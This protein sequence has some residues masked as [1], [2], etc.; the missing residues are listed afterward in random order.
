[1]PGYSSFSSSLTYTPKAS[2]SSPTN[3]KY[4]EPI[5]GTPNASESK[6]SK[7][8]VTPKTELVLDEHE[9]IISKSEHQ[10]DFPETPS[11]ENHL[12]HSIMSKLKA[13]D[14]DLQKNPEFLACL[15]KEV[16]DRI[17]QEKLF[18]ERTVEMIGL[19]DHT[20]NV[21]RTGLSKSIENRKKDLVCNTCK[22]SFPRNR[23]QRYLKHLKNHSNSYEK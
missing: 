22:V 6:Y 3:N 7:P 23:R 2:S 13:T 16:K 17:L 21:C 12:L 9:D 20:Y 1:M 5:N 14:D 8:I 19:S 11:Q 18:K 15:Q 10:K 4:F